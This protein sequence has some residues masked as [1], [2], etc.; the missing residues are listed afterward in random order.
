MLLF[1]IILIVI[2][3]ILG[4]K[5]ILPYSFFLYI[6]YNLFLVV[7]YIILYFI[8]KSGIIK[9]IIYIF[10]FVGWLFYNALGFVHSAIVDDLQ[11]V[12]CQWT[13]WIYFY[14]ILSTILLY[15][16]IKICQLRRNSM[17]GFQFVDKFCVH[18]ITILLLII[19]GV[20]IQLY[21]VYISGGWYAFIFSSY[22]SKV[23]DEY[24]TFFNFFIQ[25][26]SYIVYF[27]LPFIFLK[28][29]L[30]IK[31]IAILYWIFVIFMGCLNGSS[32][33]LVSPII[34]LFCYVYF[35]KKYRNKRRLL[36]FFL[37]IGLI[38]GIIGGVFIRTN[39]KNPEHFLFVNLQDS[40]KEVMLSPTFDNV[41]NLQ[42]IFENVHPVYQPNQFILPYIHFLPRNIF[43]WKPLELGRIVG[44]DYVGI[45]KKAKVGFLTSPIGDFYYD[46]GLFGIIVGM[47]LVGFSIGYIQEKLNASRRSPF[48]WAITVALC[49][50]FTGLS[51]WYTGC[52]SSIVKF[53]ILSIFVYIVEF[54]IRLF[55]KLM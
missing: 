33:S 31:F 54:Y 26:S 11:Q 47:V 36:K 2:L 44:Y 27:L 3:E 10:T 32:S 5:Y 53:L 14:L 19:L 9:N 34:A 48:V 35:L 21:R 8:I 22:G 23:E 25:L 50:T 41:S 42:Y 37:V 13:S 1:C 28:S 30:V 52:Y 24:L 46:F 20:S 4:W 17:V 38:I 55:R 16:P 51:A 40:F 39:R 15:I 43:P 45:N 6:L 18:N 12:H 29:N 49:C 7:N